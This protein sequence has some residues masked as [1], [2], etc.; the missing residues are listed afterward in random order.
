MNATLSA[1]SNYKFR[2]D[3]DLTKPPAFT[4]IATAQEMIENDDFLAL[5]LMYFADNEDGTDM[6]AKI[7]LDRW[8]KE[9]NLLPS[10][11]HFS[12]RGACG[13]P[14]LRAESRFRLQDTT[15]AY[16][17]NALKLLREKGLYSMPIVKD[18]ETYT[19]Q[20]NDEIDIYKGHVSLTTSDSGDSIV[21]AMLMIRGEAICSDMYVFR[22][23]ESALE[24]FYCVTSY[25][26]REHASSEV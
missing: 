11:M 25:N 1:R 6:H 24:F 21:T 5:S 19:G 4:G 13:R 16:L 9:L 26:I 17:E 12:A 14:A 2:A 18:F 7:N 22:T 20:F 23:F 10:F 8:A 15:A 3:E